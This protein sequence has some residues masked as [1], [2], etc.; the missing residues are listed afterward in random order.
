[1]QAAVDGSRHIRAIE[2]KEQGV[3]IER[4]LVR[5]EFGHIHYR[6][7]GPTGAPAI[8]LQHI[9]QQSSA[10]YL[11]L[12]A[13]LSP[14]RR[15][16]AIDYPSHGASDPLQAQPGIDDYARC[17]VAVADALD[18]GCFSVCGEAVGAATSIALAVKYPQRVTHAVLLNCPWYADRNAAQARHAPLKGGLRPE[19]A[20]GFPLTR[21]IGFL[22]DKDPGHAPLRPTQ[23][24]MDRVNL[25]Q[26]EAGRHRWQALDALHQ[27]DI[28]GS[29]ARVACPVLLLIGEHFHYL[30]YRDDFHRVLASLRS[31]VLPDARFCIGWERA[32]EV[33]QH[34]L[35]F[36]ADGD[37]PA[38]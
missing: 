21:T 27:Y 37:R 9:N 32:T 1:M 13:A 20:S 35:E 30:R 19:D 7:A 31:A 16:L 33:A 23:S 8:C 34:V 25:T 10:L 12:M 5:T 6:A 28:A 17:V 15:V 2:A 29:L 38:A 3:A 4:G 26:I 36:T 18:I 14:Q 11:E 24:W 22:L